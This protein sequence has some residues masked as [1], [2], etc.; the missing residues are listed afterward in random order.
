MLVDGVDNRFLESSSPHSLGL[1]NN[2]TIPNPGWDSNPLM[3]NQKKFW[4]EQGTYGMGCGSCGM[5][6]T[7]TEIVGAVAALAIG[8]YVYK[9]YGKKVRA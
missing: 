6:G 1:K 9:K 3:I 5:S 8:W 4:G 2:M 7:V